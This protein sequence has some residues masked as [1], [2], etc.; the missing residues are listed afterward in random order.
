MPVRLWDGA[1]WVD[2]TMHIANGSGGLVPGVVRQWPWL[3]G[4]DLVGEL[5]YPV[6]AGNRFGMSEANENTLFAANTLFTNPNLQA[7]LP[8]ICGACDLRVLTGE[9]G[10]NSL[11]LSF[12]SITETTASQWNS[13]TIP[14]PLGGGSA[15][16]ATFWD[17]ASYPAKSV[18]R[19]WAGKQVLMP[20]IKVAAAVTPLID[21]VEAN[22]AFGNIIAVSEAYSECTTMAAANLNVLYKIPSGAP[23]DGTVASPAT[24]AAAGIMGV[25]MPAGNV[26]LTIVNACKAAGLKVWVYTVNT[27]A[28]AEAQIALGVDGIY[29]DNPSTA[30]QPVAPPPPSG[31]LPVVYGYGADVGGGTWN[32]VSGQMARGLLKPGVVRIFTGSG[33]ASGLPQSFITQAKNQGAAIWVSWKP[34]ASIGG[35]MENPSSWAPSSVNWLKTNVGKNTP[36]FMCVWHEPEGDDSRNGR[37]VSTWQAIWR[38]AHSALYEQCLAARA[39]GYQFYVAPI[40]CD[41]T[42]WDTSKGSAQTWYPASWTEYDLMGWDMYP[43]GQK[44]SGSRMIARLATLGDYQPDI[45]NSEQRTNSGAR[46]DSYRTMRLIAALAKS[47]GKPWGSGETGIIRG[48]EVGGDSLH[49]YSKAQRA[50]L[51]YDITNDHR[52]LDPAPLL[53][54]WYSH[55]GCNIVDEPD[56]QTIEAWNASIRLN[57]TQFP[58][59]Q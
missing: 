12:N 52:N 21:W 10:V 32:G 3:G 2:G 25:Q 50:Q 38:D 36:C 19:I 8:R 41:W 37:P 29:T 18:A 58:V 4:D 42:F 35:G 57:P 45:Y 47:R 56:L 16:P 48:A 44:A 34:S 26:N 53:W 6:Y 54:C 14:S 43:R 20:T 17:N 46:N 39:E 1:A 59:F 40:I 23:G 15:Q 22:N 7:V 24:I 9:T 49:K 51:Y 5:N 11:V 31:D 13:K 28:L 30:T 27:N 33:N 55:G